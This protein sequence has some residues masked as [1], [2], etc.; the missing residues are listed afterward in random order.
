MNI[1]NIACIYGNVGLFQKS[2]M[3]QNKPLHDFTI[4]NHAI[5]LKTW[6]FMIL[7]LIKFCQIFYD[8][9][10]CFNVIVHNN[11]FIARKIRINPPKIPI[12][13]DGNLLKK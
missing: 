1:C 8:M 12:Y 9:P 11:A 13:F 5:M 6:F 4:L 7:A 10:V 2:I 3:L